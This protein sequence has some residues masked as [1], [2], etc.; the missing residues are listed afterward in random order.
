EPA[1]Q[2]AQQAVAEARRTGAWV[3][4]LRALEICGL[5]EARWGNPH[6]A[7]AVYDEGLQR[8]GAIPF[9]YAEARLLHA[10]SLLEHQGGDRVS[11]E[12]NRSAAHAIFETLGAAIPPG[13]TTPI[14]SGE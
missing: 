1:R 8:A 12:T 10:Y 9:P 13:A 2:Y 6:L 3:N 7:R 14:Q 5:V 11:A 4:G